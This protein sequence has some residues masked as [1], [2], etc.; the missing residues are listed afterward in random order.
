MSCG[1]LAVFLLI[2]D[3]PVDSM[4]AFSAVDASL[5]AEVY[6]PIREVLILRTLGCV[7]EGCR[8]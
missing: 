7:Q 4:H 2:T 1:W 6:V 5:D 8:C 3:I